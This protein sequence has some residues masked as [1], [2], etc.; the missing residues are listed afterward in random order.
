M[1]HQSAETAFEDDQAAVDLARANA[2]LIGGGPGLRGR[3]IPSNPQTTNIGLGVVH[4]YR[5]RDTTQSLDGWSKLHDETE[6]RADT[7]VDEEDAYLDKDN[8]TL[9]ILAVPSYMTPAD[10]LGWIGE[11]TADRISHLRLVKSSR[12]NKYMVLMKFR[13]ADKASEW[14]KLWNGKPFNSMEVSTDEPLTFQ[15]DQV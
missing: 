12:A 7:T 13:D 9:C 11:E 4:L 6:D 14:Q 2:H 15:C 10:L 1:E 5:D 8:T 3:Y